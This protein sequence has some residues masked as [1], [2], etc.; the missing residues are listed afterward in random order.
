MEAQKKKVLVK[1]SIQNNN[2]KENGLKPKKS[3]PKKIIK[4]SKT[5]T[6]KPKATRK[7]IKTKRVMPVKNAEIPQQEFIE[8]EMPYEHELPVQNM[9]HINKE[10]QLKDII[11][12]TKTTYSYSK[13]L[14]TTVVKPVIVQ[15]VTTR[16]PIIA[17]VDI[18]TPVNFLEG[19]PLSSE[20][21]LIQNFFNNTSSLVEAN[22]KDYSN[23]YLFQGNNFLPQSVQFTTSQIQ[24]QLQYNNFN[25]TS[26]S[27][28]YP[29]QNNNAITQINIEAGNFTLPTI[30][31]VQQKNVI[32]FN[33]QSEREGQKKIINK[34]IARTQPKTQS[35]KMRTVKKIVKSQG[36]LKKNQ[37]ISKSLRPQEKIEN[38][39]VNNMLKSTYPVL[40]QQKK[41]K[42]QKYEETEEKIPKDSIR[43][44]K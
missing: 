22:E 28:Q 26:Q 35:T 24:P 11:N 40:I 27:V 2:S 18:R 12:K 37:D 23:S 38:I 31:K 29:S 5:S 13:A 33:P 17:P 15:E 14:R 7:I 21:L 8:S 25:Y 43:P 39:T 1:Q 34:P 9:E 20:D 6:G 30:E 32:E 44:K 4:V 36:R 16:K 3:S 41:I 10:Y 42:E 19:K